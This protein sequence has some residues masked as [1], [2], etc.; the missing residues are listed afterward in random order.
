MTW[1]NDGVRPVRPVVMLGQDNRRLAPQSSI[2]SKTMRAT[3]VKVTGLHTREAIALLF[4]L[5]VGCGSS[6]PSPTGT[7]QPQAIPA[8]TPPSP[9][10]FPPLSGPSRTFTFARASSYR[11]S[12][13][14]TQSRFVLYDNGA[15]VLQYVGLGIQYRGGYTEAKGAIAFEWEG[16]STAGPW[17]A[18]ATVKGDSLT[19][20]YNV[21]MQLTDFEDA[22]YTATP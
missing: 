2:P 10:N 19:V 16:W 14:T 5:S 18:T 9:T 12:D 8:A 3:A 11:V 17:G 4:V 6:A 1:H 20:Q 22:V 21:I 7:S 15:F 13:Y